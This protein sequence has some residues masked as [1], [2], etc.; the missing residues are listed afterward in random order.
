MNKLIRIL[1]AATLIVSASTAQLWAGDMCC[2]GDTPNVAGISGT[3]AVV[4]KPVEQSQKYV[5]PMHPD[6]IY[7]KPGKCPKCGMRLL[8]V[9]NETRTNK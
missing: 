6:V 8:P 5:C 4:L 3:P 9:K 2:G 7:D 1:A